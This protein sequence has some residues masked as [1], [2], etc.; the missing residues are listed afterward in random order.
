MA[1]EGQA[2]TPGQVRDQMRARPGF[3]SK[4]A[5]ALGITQ[6]TCGILSIVFGIAVLFIPSG[7]SYIIYSPIVCGAMV[8]TTQFELHNLAC[9][10]LKNTLRF[11][12]MGFGFGILLFVPFMTNVANSRLASCMWWRKPDYPAKTTA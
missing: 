4:T 5:K 1:T 7:F 10:C 9:M 2:M 6:L 3:A 11:T 12:M 8:S